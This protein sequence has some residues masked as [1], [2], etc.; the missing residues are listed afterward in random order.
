MSSI[1]EKLGLNNN[2]DNNQT[3][4]IREKLGITKQSLEDEKNDIELQ[5]R[6]KEENSKTQV[7][8]KTTGLKWIDANLNN[9]D[10]KTYQNALELSDYQNDIPAIK[11]GST[12]GDLVVN[13]GI[14]LMGTAENLVDLGRYGVAGVADLIGA[15]DYAND[16]RERAKQDTTS[17]I[18]SPVEDFFNKNSLLKENGIIENVAQGVGQIG[19]IIGSGGLLP[20]AI[21]TVNVG[22]FAMPTTS[23]LSGAG[24]GMTEAYNNG[25]TDGQAFLAG[26]GIGGIEGI[27]EALFGG[28]GNTFAKKFG[29]GALDDVLIKKLT[30]KISNKTLQTLA[31]SGLKAAGEGFEEVIS[32]LG[33]AF[34]KKLTYMNKEDIGKLIN[35]EDLLNSFVVGT[36]TSAVAQTPSTIKSI[37]TGNSYI[38]L[39]NDNQVNQNTLQNI[40]NNTPDSSENIQSN[41]NISTNQNSVEN[42]AQ[43]SLNEL[44]TNSNTQ[45][46]RYLPTNNEKSNILKQSASKYFNNSQD[47]INLL[48]TID[49]VV[50]DKGY[51]IL[52]DNTIVNPNGQSVNA[53]IKNL[54]N[55]EL[56]IRINPNSNRAGEFLIMHEVTHAIENDSMKKLIIDYASKNSEFS[57]ALESLKQTY[58]TN[59]VS[60]EVVADIS[61]QLFGNQ[62]FINNLSMQ[63]PN[64]FKRIYNK[65]IEL[66]NKI[67]GNSKQSLFIKDLKNKWETAYRNTSTEQAINNINEVQY[68]ISPNFSNEID[69]V[70]NGTYESQNQVKARDYTPE[71]LVNNGVPNLPMLITAKHIKSTIYSQKE[72]QKLGLPTNKNINYHGLGKELLIKSIDS[73]DNPLA[74]YKQSENNYIIITE[75]Q[76]NNGKNII[77]PIEING[78]GT[79]ND[80]FID[81]NQI[82][83]AYGK[84]NLEKYIQNNNLEKIYEK[85][86]ITLNERVQYSNIGN[87]V[88]NNIPQSDNVV[89]SDTL[90][91]YSMQNNENN[92]Q[93]LDSSSFS[94]KQKQLEIIQNNN[95]VQD[96]YHTWIRNIDDIKTLEETIN[97]SDWID[98]DEFNPDLTRQNIKDA[99]NSGKITVYSSYPIE[100]G[101]FVSPSKMEAESY[102]SDGKVYSKEVNIDDI[103]WI[104]PTQGQ[105]AKVQTS[106]ADIRYSQENDNWQEY[107]ENNYKATG[108]RTNMK[109]LKLPTANK[110]T[111]T[112]NKTL[113]GDV[114]PKYNDV[115]NITT[116]ETKI[117]PKDPTKESSYNNYKEYKKTRKE[118]QQELQDEMGITVENLQIGKDISSLEYQRTD[119]IRLNEKVFG[120]EIGKKI[121]DA[122]INKTKHNE[123]ERIRFLNKERD[124]IKNLG[125]KPRSKESAAVQKYGEKQY[126]NDKGDV[127][128]YSDVNLSTE[129]PNIE[130]QQKIKRAAEVIRNKYDKYIDTINQTITELGY[131]P[132]PKRKDYMR[133]FQELNDKFTQWGLPLNRQSLNEN[134]IPT[135]INGLTDQFKPGKNWFAS[136]MQRKGLKTT[137]DAITGIDGYLDGASN[138]MYHTEDIQRYRALSKLVRDTFGQTHGLDN[139]DLSTE[140]G[141]QRLNDIYDNKLSKYAA[142]LDEQAN[143]L[144]GKK[145]AIDRG[146]ERVLGRKIYSVL[147]AAKKQV[148]SNM[149]GFN[150]RSAL[151]NFAS[152]I[153]GASKTNKLA[154]IK[155][156]I[157]TVQNMIHNDGLIN[158]SDFLTSRFGSDQLSKKLW[159]KASNAGQ[160]LMTGSDYFTANQIWRSKY[161]ENLSKGMSETQAIKNA[162]EFSSRIMGDRSKGATAE[163]FNSKT[164]GLFTQFQL[165]VNNQWSSLIHDN[166]IDIRNGNKTGATVLF[167]MGQLAAMSYMFNNFMKSV[168]G[169]GV[170]ID[171][172]DLLK[173]IFGSDDEDD[174]SI[175]ERAT[176]V[177][178]DIVNNLPFASVFTGG[179]IPVSEA[180]KG[181]STGFKYATGQSDNYGNKYKI[182]DVGDDLIESAFY[183]LL[184]TGYGQAKKT[185]KGL[186]MYSGSLPTAGS[187]TNSGNLRFTAD[188]TVGG[189]IKAALFG[190]YSSKEAQDYI[191]SGYKT[192]SKNN[193]QEMKDLNMTSSEYRQYRQGLSNAGT[194]NED[195]LD[196]INNLDVSTEQKN[197]MAN[198]V[199][200]SKKYTI[201]MEDYNNYD[202]YE[203]MKYSLDNPQKYNTLTSF[204]IKYNDYKNYQEKVSEIKEK[205]SGTSNAELR[206]SKVKQY[207][208]SLPYSRNQK[209]MLYKSLG[210]YSIKDYKDEMF[211]YIES[212]KI[213]KTEKQ[214]IWKQLYGGD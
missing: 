85:K 76:D 153:Q 11:L 160:I 23:I 6:I 185:I 92:T 47:T 57:Q 162:D 77:V 19:G 131:D 78:K 55:G 53:Q 124:E 161:Y 213:T 132:I 203:E 107:V 50:Q 111:I 138:L 188:E 133:H 35:D 174:K 119:P 147:D 96:D 135:D 181:I 177:L 70:L 187:Y 62:E 69:Q 158:K 16:V 83:S 87:S 204:N 200:D 63:Q 26:L 74:I 116:T 2:E 166:K 130:T 91:K 33:N 34:V 108:T 54:S 64:I 139:V 49:K 9:I 173:K 193:I 120:A 140:E 112:N 106:D 82:K 146:T 45:K 192:I 56:E 195:K 117:L 182:S 10:D 169:S 125:I 143:A 122:T 88:E 126:I 194:K 103:A 137:Y 95:P 134:N 24:S 196:Y 136:A 80:L 198:N 14:G 39:D 184:P 199:V 61:G 109:S 42:G 154:F 170:M 66:A 31:Q 79:Y 191:D 113:K 86:G 208:E 211:S 168:T 205:Y 93:E 65:I 37:K 60:S 206:K 81:E 1:R 43:N 46:Y 73:L 27:S 197:I 110:E 22:K 201:D 17:M 72:A 152:S 12:A 38:N 151:T 84:N 51:N 159:Q 209:I 142:W 115:G 127:I 68:H 207:I 202:S 13:A 183:W 150:V 21:S 101:I 186:S 48:N 171:P 178:G 164:L 41:I 18:L 75:I 114:L 29:G 28:L 102:S 25:A 30:D 98:Y 3:S 7:T 89:N 129:F 5:Q 149:T 97:D 167:Q 175:E 52:F 105:Y 156:T 189:K 59:D 32:G 67:T 99:I 172:I 44:T 104:D 94:L 36:L 214:E 163:I 90:P 157:S 179:R 141:Q 145:G 210:N 128:T 212:L 180:F 8:R 71:I 58:G 121:N 118:I 176:N 165:E 100:Q 15:K 144:A 148:G 190:Q 4:S 40:T 123:A 20:K 155:G